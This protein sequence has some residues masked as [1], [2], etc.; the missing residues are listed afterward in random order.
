MF[1]PL[2]L[3]Q[4]SAPAVTQQPTTMELVGYQ[5]V[6]HAL[7]DGRPDPAAADNYYVRTRSQWFLITD[8]DTLPIDADGQRHIVFPERFTREYKIDNQIGELGGAP[9]TLFKELNYVNPEDRG[10]RVKSSTGRMGGMNFF[11]P[12]SQRMLFFYIR[13]VVDQVEVRSVGTK[14][15][16]RTSRH[17]HWGVSSHGWTSG[18]PFL[19]NPEPQVYYQSREGHVYEPPTYGYG[20]VVLPKDYDL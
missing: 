12:A 1:A 9:F 6:Q 19:P 7:P 15:A 5:R 20:Q 8:S 3:A 4:T 16:I 13:T 2:L 10:K 14:S 11:R 17:S 18:K